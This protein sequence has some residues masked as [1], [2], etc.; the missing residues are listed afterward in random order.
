[1]ILKTDWVKWSDGEL[2]NCY[3]AFNGF[4][5]YKTQRFKDTRYD[6][7]GKVLKILLI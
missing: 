6:G 1:M 3:S 7:I 4:A 2:L 5:I